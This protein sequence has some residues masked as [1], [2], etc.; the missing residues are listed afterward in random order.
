MNTFA[1]QI[2]RAAVLM[3]IPITIQDANFLAEICAL[4]NNGYRLSI[5]VLR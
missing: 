1:M 4:N 2:Q 3:P 5:K